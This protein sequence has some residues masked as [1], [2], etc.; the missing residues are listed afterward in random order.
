MTSRHCVGL[1]VRESMMIFFIA[2]VSGAS[3]VVPARHRVDLEQ[4][5]DDIRRVVRIEAARVVLR[6]LRTDVV[7]QIRECVPVP[8][9]AVDASVPF[10]HRP[11]RT[12][13]GA[14]GT[15]T[16]KRA[17]IARRREDADAGLARAGG[18]G[19]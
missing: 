6:H 15:A 8:S 17:I 10:S 13:A 5:G 16:S 2:S 12:S 3:S 14:G 18:F 1:V 4:V 19:L 9:H 7:E 11:R